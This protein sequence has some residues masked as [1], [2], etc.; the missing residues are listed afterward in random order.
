MQKKVGQDSDLFNFLNHFLFSN[1]LPK[2]S[3]SSICLKL[4]VY[5]TYFIIDWKHILRIIPCQ[6]RGQKEK[7]QT[8]FL[9]LRSLK[10]AWTKVK[11]IGKITPE[12]KT[13]MQPNWRNNF[14]WHL[15]VERFNWGTGQF[16]HT[17]T[18]IMVWPGR[19]WSSRSR[20][21]RPSRRRDGSSSAFSLAP[22]NVH[23]AGRKLSRA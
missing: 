5:L 1:F 3:L 16:G 8:L 12:R 6:K 10:E 21:W 15:S 19:P 20:M 4:C 18:H 14:F 23:T 7:G 11:R 17:Y 22:A 9:A 2:C 13:R